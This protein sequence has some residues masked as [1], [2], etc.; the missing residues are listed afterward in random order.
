M[1]KINAALKNKR[2]Q[3]PSYLNT[4]NKNISMFDHTMGKCPIWDFN[5]TRDNVVEEP[6]QFIVPLP[7]IVVECENAQKLES[8]LIIA[9][10]YMKLD[11]MDVF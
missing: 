8:Y 11:Y 4:F 5:S 10:T 7:I 9:E 2:L 6:P 3:C 1:I